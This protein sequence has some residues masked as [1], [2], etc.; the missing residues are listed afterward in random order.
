[1]LTTGTDWEREKGCVIQAQ[2][3]LLDAD[4]KCVVEASGRLME[5]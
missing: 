3:G 4:V 2:L 5:L 1:M